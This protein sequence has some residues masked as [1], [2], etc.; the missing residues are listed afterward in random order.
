MPGPDARGAD[1]RLTQAGTPV[2]PLLSFL[3]CTRNRAHQIPHCLSS[4]CASLQAAGHPTAEIVC[5]DNGSGDGTG[6][7]LRAW[8]STAPVP[9]HILDEPRPGLSRARNTGLRFTSGEI[10]A[11]TDDDCRLAPGHVRDLLAHD[12][13]DG[14][15]LVLRGGRVLLGDPADLPYTIKDQDEPEHYGIGPGERR[16]PHLGGVVLSC[17]MAMRRP[18]MERVGPFDERLGTGAPL[19]AGEDTDYLSRAYLAGI[20][21][22]YVPDMAVLH[23]HGRRD[24]EALRRLIDAYA[25]GNGGYFVKVL[26]RDW[27]LARQAWW[28]GR[29]AL[30]ELLRIRP[31]YQEFGVGAPRRFRG[32]L[33][34]A[35]RFL[36]YSLRR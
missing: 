17:N 28:D 7:A 21:I 31:S 35:A 3:V 32:Y 24:V 9:V 16:P 2:A 19:R 5:V 33:R 30:L 27:R 14:A 12:A 18:V 22:E 20:A 34:G 4:I 10:L 8:A 29:D 23:F 15:R 26:P 36:W 1:G 13:R 25:E 6:Q 11:F